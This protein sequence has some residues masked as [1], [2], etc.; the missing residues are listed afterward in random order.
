MQTSRRR[1]E[2]RGER[3]EAASKHCLAALGWEGQLDKPVEGAH[4][5]SSNEGWMG[6]Q[7][8]VDVA[9]D[10]GVLVGYVIQA[11]TARRSRGNVRTPST[12]EGASQL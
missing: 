1:Y 7:H 8:G 12:A 6:R 2:W 3:G 11:V 5:L 9:R 4:R 10:L